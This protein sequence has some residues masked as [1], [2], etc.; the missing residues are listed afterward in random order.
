MNL[1]LTPACSNSCPYC[2]EKAEQQKGKHSLISDEN[3]M[4]FSKWAH[5]SRLPFLSLLGGEPFLHPKLGSIVKTMRQSCPWIGL[6]ILTGGIFNKQLLDNICPED[7][8]IGFN[9]NEPKGYLNPKH[10]NKVIRNVEIAI[11]KGFRVSLSFNVWRPDFD[12][13]FIPDLAHKFA[14]SNF[15]WTVANPILGCPSKVVSPSQFGLIADRCFI[16]LQEAARLNIEALLD[17]PLPVCFFNE[18]QLAWVRQYHPATASVMGVC[19]PALDV[20]PDLKVLRCFALSNLS[21]INLLDF[22]NERELKDWFLNNIDYRL[23]NE[24]CFVE[25]SQCVH[26]TTGRCYGGCLGNHEIQD[27]TF[28]TA[29]LPSLESRMEMAIEAGNPAQALSLYQSSNYWI[30]TDKASFRAAEAS[31]KVGDLDQAFRFASR[32]L[33]QTSDFLLL[34]QIGEFIAGLL[35]G[36]ISALNEQMIDNNFPNYVSCNALHSSSDQ[37]KV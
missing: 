7:V 29:L 11:R 8:S 4:R 14:R 12:T 31:L 2:F 13:N 18:Q 30:K 19:E 37:N 36:N 3:I 16:M 10:F 27:E 26:K 21:R 9:I 32:A 22:H 24:G 20:T 5:D 15:S 1:V 33:D 23:L 6:R 25:C 35:T 34:K 28:E 17:C